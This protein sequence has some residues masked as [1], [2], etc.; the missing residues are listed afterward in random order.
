[1]SVGLPGGSVLSTVPVG[2]YPHAAIRTAG[3]TIAVADELGGAFV[4][5]RDGRVVRRFTD[6]TQPGGVAA[7]GDQ[8]GVVDVKDRTLSLY[9]TKAPRRIS[10]VDA[11]DGP[12]HMVADRRGHLLVADTRGNRLLTFEVTPRLR[13]IGSVPL[14]GTPYGMAYDD[15]RDRLWVT[16]TA[17]NQVVGLDLGGSKPAVVATLP[18]VRQPNTVA[19]DSATGRVFVASRTDGTVQLID[20][21]TSPRGQ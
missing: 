6:V 16:L 13:R 4:L 18:T 8:V 14:D 3:G 7:V 1:M 11:G 2:K 12:T 21:P 17:R 19:V 5:V 20:P 9:D 15:V 10:V